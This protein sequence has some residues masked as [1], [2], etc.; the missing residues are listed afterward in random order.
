MAAGP[1]TD[2]LVAFACSQEVSEHVSWL[3]LLTNGLVAF[4]CSQRVSEVV[5]WLQI[6]LLMVLWH[7]PPLRM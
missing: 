2:G 6:L 1:L 4:A 7:L 3:Q 5:L